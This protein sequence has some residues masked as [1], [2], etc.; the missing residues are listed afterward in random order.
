M[1]YV[2]LPHVA[3]GD[4]ATAPLHNT[5]L[6]NVAII[7]SNINDDGFLNPIRRLRAANGTFSGTTRTD[8]N[9]V[10][11]PVLTDLDHLVIRWGIKSGTGFTSGSVQVRH[12][13][14]NAQIFD[15]NS[16]V[17]LNAGERIGGH[18]VLSQQKGL[19][20]TY[21][22]E[23]FFSADA[24][25]ALGSVYSF[26]SATASW[27]SAWTLGLSLTQTSGTADWWWSVILF[28]GQ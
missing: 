11:L 20:T 24:R 18:C 2:I 17:N 27:A 25:G 9:T 6:D 26:Y 23:G 28:A 13:T 12:V 1:S 19:A 8:V 10:V 3:T 22:Y 14:D 15:A 21:L 7:K 16:G 4:M 5:F